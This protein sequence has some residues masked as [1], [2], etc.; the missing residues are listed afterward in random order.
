MFQRFILAITDS[1]YEKALL[2]LTTSGGKWVPLIKAEI[3]KQA[4]PKAK[5]EGFMKLILQ[6]AKSSL[7]SANSSL[8]GNTVGVSLNSIMPSNSWK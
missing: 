2:R 1:S 6:A 8:I 7:P 5:S 4:T 3:I